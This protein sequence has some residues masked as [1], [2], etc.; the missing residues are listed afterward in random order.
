MDL[1]EVT[2]NKNRHPWEISRASRILKELPKFYEGDDVLDVGCG[3]GY[4]DRMIARKFPS[5]NFYGID[6]NLPRSYSEGN[7]SF[8][9]SY[10][11]LPQKKFDCIILMDVL[12]HIKDDTEF[13][14]KISQRLKYNGTILITVPA[15]MKLYSAH[16]R[17]VKHYRRYEHKRLLKLIKKCG[18]KEVKWSY[19]YM[20]LILGRCL[21]RNR[22]QDTQGFHCVGKWKWAQNHII[23]KVIT[24]ILNIDYNF[25]IFCSKRNVHFP[26]LSLLSVCKKAGSFINELRTN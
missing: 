18:L 3:D 26:G 20:S 11:A 5:A 10:E 9:N 21:T 22:T 4:F 7:V 14:A 15:F 16:D 2:G 1:L 17:E 13:L 8:F 19:F 12:E 23:T 24:S 25:L 6:I